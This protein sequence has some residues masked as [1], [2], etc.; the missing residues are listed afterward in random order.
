VTRLTSIGR[1][2]LTRRKLRYLLTALGIVLGVANVFGVLVTNATTNRSVERRAETFFG[3]A[4]VVAQRQD[5][6]QPLTPDTVGRLRKAPDA[7]AA[8]FWQAFDVDT[9][10]DKKDHFTLGAAD[11]VGAA[12]AIAPRLV[13]GRM[14]TAGRAE[15]VVSQRAAARLHLAVGGEWSTNLSGY[16]TG[17]RWDDQ[18]AGVLLRL[19]PGAPRVLHFR[20][21]GMISDLPDQATYPWA[22]YTSLDYVWSVMSPRLATEARFFLHRDADATAW[23]SARSE[24][25][26]GVDFTPAALPADFRRFLNVLQGAMSGAA[27]IAVFVGG[28]LIYLTFS[29]SVVERTR[30]YGMLHAVGSTRRQVARAVVAE[31]MMLGAIATAIG[32]LLGALL[33]LVLLRI[34]AGVV[35]VP[36]TSIT[37]P[38]VAIVVAVVVGFA[39]TLAGSLLPARRAAR[40]SPVEAIRG[41]GVR[42]AGAS[43][44][45]WIVG[46]LLVVA[47]LVFS[48]S[49][50]GLQA[51]GIV[52]QL[53]TL[54]L[55]LGAVLVLPPILAAVVRAGRRVIRRLTGELG[56][57]S[58]M[59]LARERSR[60]AYTLGL[61]MVVLAMMLAL[62]ATSGSV[63]RSVTTWVDKRFGADVLAYHGDMPASAERTV[64]AVPGVSAVTS[65]AFAPVRITAPV[66]LTSNIVLVDPAHFFTIAGFPWSD[67]DDA[68]ARRALAAD[69]V[70]LPG[71]LA[72][73]EHVH[74]GGYVTL[75]TRFGPA[76]FPVAG[77]YAAFGS[78]SEIGVVAGVGQVERFLASDHRNVLY[79]NLAPGTSHHTAIEAM[80][81]ALARTQSPGDLSYGGPA[82]T[83]LHSGYFFVEGATIKAQARRNVRSYFSLFYAVLLVAVLV[84]LLGL[85]NTM[86]TSVL[87]RYREIGVLGAVGARARDVRRM[88]VAEAGVLVAIAFVLS[89]GLGTLLARLIVDGVTRLVGF[90]V[91][92]LFPWRSLPGLVVL[93]ASIALASAVLPARRAARLTPVEALRYE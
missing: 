45:V 82:Q 74:R 73:Q 79:V 50:R 22:S 21:T 54:G 27:T 85:A 69:G 19:R 52:P 28:F 37:V 10:R 2:E 20:I 35:Q 43:S 7:A 87:H 81:A 5:D 53:A 25:F 6:T 75:T 44:R 66:D 41:V 8:F 63:G 33:S 18:P 30:M 56:D 88:V 77:V 36:V 13:R 60:S 15:A 90:R 89:L 86:A 12:R 78:G 48:V 1:R 67:G 16:A 55:L 39:A 49:T 72:V 32:L 61:V 23:A 4:D 17:R 31:A 38:P 24:E 14:F 93:A 58:L 71:N 34:V 65:V 42:S 40:L 3:G 70:L 51:S 57:V 62:T 76:R 26:T 92:F 47:S 84:G 9:T 64:A 46:A 59:H 91:A 68:S 11:D 29:M 80:D 83:R